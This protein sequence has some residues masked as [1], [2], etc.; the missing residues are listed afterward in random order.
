M[1]D[2]DFTEPPNIY[3]KDPAVIASRYT[4]PPPRSGDGD[5]AQFMKKAEARKRVKTAARP[6]GPTERR[7]IAAIQGDSKAAQRLLH[8]RT[9]TAG[10]HPLVLRLISAAAAGDL[11]EVTALLEDGEVDINGQDGLGF[12]ALFEAAFFG[13]VEV[14]K[15][16]IAAGPTSTRKTGPARRRRCTGSWTRRRGGSCGRLRRMWAVGRRCRCWYPRIWRRS[17]CSCGTARF[18][19]IGGGIGWIFGAWRASSGARGPSVPRGGAGAAEVGYVAAHRGGG[20]ESAHVDAE[21]GARDVEPGGGGAAGDKAE[22]QW[23]KV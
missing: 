23:V 10:A 20:A 5:N 11:G 21:G 12:S 4:N 22:R 6:L 19:T 9:P 13:R 2:E 3:S 8:D 16:L 14:V 18:G 17:R 1:A 15:A 7:Y